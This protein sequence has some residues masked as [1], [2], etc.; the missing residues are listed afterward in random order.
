MLIKNVLH[1][2]LRTLE[3]LE[4]LLISFKPLN[5]CERAACP[6][7]CLCKSI[8]P[9]STQRVAKLTNISQFLSQKVIQLDGPPEGLG[10]EEADMLLRHGTEVEISG[11][12]G[13]PL[14]VSGEVQDLMTKDNFDITFVGINGKVV[15]SK[16]KIARKIWFAGS[17]ILNLKAGRKEE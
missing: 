3:S 8:S 10:G 15:K 7:V 11:V 12:P 16:V 13:S 17:I 9:V 1:S 2:S 4:T 14:I 5:F 6:S